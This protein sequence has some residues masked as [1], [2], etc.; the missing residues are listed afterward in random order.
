[1]TKWFFV[2]RLSGDCY[3][4]F[5]PDRSQA[6]A[7]CKAA[8]DLDWNNVAETPMDYEVELL[9]YTTIN[10]ETGMRL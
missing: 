6:Q 3:T 1:M 5:A 8:L 2:S 7:L 4:V 9:C 10:L